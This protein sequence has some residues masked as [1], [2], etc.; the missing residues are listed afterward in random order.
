M[1]L[2]TYENAYTFQACMSPATAPPFCVKT[3]IVIENTFILLGIKSLCS[4]RAPRGPGE[5][6][7][8]AEVLFPMHWE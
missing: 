4:L 1:S 2:K 3:M 6:V 7:F 5:C 8:S